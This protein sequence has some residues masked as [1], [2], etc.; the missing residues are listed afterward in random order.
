MDWSQVTALTIPEGNVVKV[1]V[2]NS[3]LWEK[4]KLL[5]FG[6]TQL[7]YI[8]STGTQYIDT[9]FTFDTSTKVHFVFE[10][11]GANVGNT[12]S[13]RG[14][15]I[16]G[17]NNGG[18]EVLICYGNSHYVRTQSGFVG[19]TPALN[20]KIDVVIDYTKGATSLTID[21][22]SKGTSTATA[23]NYKR[24]LLFA[25][26]GGADSADNSATVFMKQKMYAFE[27]WNGEDLIQK[28][29]PAMRISD[30]EVGM[31]DT[32]TNTFFTNVG[33]G[34]FKAGYTL[35]SEFTRLDYIEGV[36]HG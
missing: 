10:K 12:S 9:G 5:P 3:I 11:T 16:F 24:V 34:A 35:P 6:Y 27:M 14:T 30:S 8:E 17:S 36:V 4:K 7:D 23:S 28:L 25:G 13:G 22:V 29:I 26:V 18:G 15:M 1:S 32:V 2:G 21:G 33:T 19:Y 20:T 31:Y